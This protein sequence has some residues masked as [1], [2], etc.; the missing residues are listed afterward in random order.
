MTEEDCE[1]MEDSDLM[2]VRAT[3]TSNPRF[4][5]LT[6]GPS[7]HMKLLRH[8]ISIEIDFRVMK[9][10]LWYAVGYGDRK[11]VKNL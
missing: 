6:V 5:E 1:C 2:E 11:R 4:I 9:S 10:I 3:L 7:T 8:M